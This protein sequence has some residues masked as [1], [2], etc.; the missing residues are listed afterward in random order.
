ME[1]KVANCLREAERQLNNAKFI[2]GAG[3]GDCMMYD[4]I[5]QIGQEL[6]DMINALEG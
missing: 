4:R 6:L 5:K 2:V 1:Q 3:I